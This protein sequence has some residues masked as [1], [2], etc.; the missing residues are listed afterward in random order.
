MKTV[1]PIV[2]AARASSH[3][4]VIRFPANFI[5]GDMIKEPTSE[6]SGLLECDTLLMGVIHYILND[7]SGCT[8]ENKGT[9]VLKVV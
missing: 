9:V 1:I 4:V 2:T 5:G 7:R 8:H 3:N 6:D